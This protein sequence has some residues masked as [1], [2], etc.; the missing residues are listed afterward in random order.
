MNQ[1][2]TTLD[3]ATLTKAVVRAAERLELIGALPQI[4]GISAQVVD[5][6]RAGRAHLDPTHAEWQTAI[7]FTGL[8]RALLSLVGSIENARTWLTTPHQTLASAPATLLQTPEGMEL[9]L[10]YL[11]NVQK[12]E[13]KLPPRG[14]LQ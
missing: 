14:R 12:Y 13:I 3:P 8:F 9:V 7:H 11:G 4:L 10:R 2:S 1:S 6:W 5:E